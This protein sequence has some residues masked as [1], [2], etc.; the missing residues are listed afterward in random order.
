MIE[1]VAEPG[2]DVR[3]KADLDAEFSAYFAARRQRLMRTAYLLTGDHHAAEDLVQTALAR[4]YAAWR[5]IR[6]DGSIDAYVRRT[7]VNAHLGLWRRAWRRLERSTDQVPDEAAPVVERSVLDERVRDAIRRL[8]PRQ[9]AV[10]VLRYYED[11]SE[12]D[13]ADALGC[14]TGTVKSTAARSLV[15]LREYLEENQ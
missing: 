11:L 7:L 5:R 2:V 4:V 8:A 1:A 10:V 15:K 13:I 14:S 12:A 9:R 6:R 3:G